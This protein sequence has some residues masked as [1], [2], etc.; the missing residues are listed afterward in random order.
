[1][2]ITDNKPFKAAVSRQLDKLPFVRWDRF[3]YCTSSTGRTGVEVYG[4][5]DRKKDAYK[6]FLLL[7]IWEDGG[8]NFNTSSAARSLEI[9]RILVGSGR[10]HQKCKRVEDFFTAKNAIKL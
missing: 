7:E 4:W 6:D 5:I 10:G 3:V 8:V 9:F 1:M 2:K